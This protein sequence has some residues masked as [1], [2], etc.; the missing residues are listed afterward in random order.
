MASVPDIDVPSSLKPSAA[1]PS[2]ASAFWNFFR[3]GS[4]SAR[5]RNASRPAGEICVA[6]GSNGSERDLG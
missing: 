3:I 1:R 5:G 6:S 2:T 4:V